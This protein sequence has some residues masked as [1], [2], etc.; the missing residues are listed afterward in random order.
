ML[1]QVFGGL[2]FEEGIFWQGWGLQWN[3]QAWIKYFLPGKSPANNLLLEGIL[4][5][6]MVEAIIVRN[7]R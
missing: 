4:C 6:E 2:L 7:C 3:Y 1:K 5:F